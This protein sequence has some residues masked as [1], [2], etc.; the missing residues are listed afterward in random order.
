M[1]TITH[2]NTTNVTNANGWVIGSCTVKLKGMNALPE[3]HPAILFWLGNNWEIE[4]GNHC[5]TLDC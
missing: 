2:H 3:I 5:T 1:Y 4:I